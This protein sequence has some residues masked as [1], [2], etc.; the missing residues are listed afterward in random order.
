MIHQLRPQNQCQQAISL[1]GQSHPAK[2]KRPSPP[3]PPLTA[4]PQTLRGLTGAVIRSMAHIAERYSHGYESQV[5]NNC[6]DFQKDLDRRIPYIILR[7]G[8][9]K[10]K[11]DVSHVCA[12]FTYKHGALPHKFGHQARRQQ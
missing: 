2:Y 6:H 11:E 7:D 12:M 5:S 8:D 9:A 3:P 4:Q 1:P 10:P